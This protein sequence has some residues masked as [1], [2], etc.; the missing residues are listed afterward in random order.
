M[1]RK[2]WQIADQFVAGGV[3]RGESE[4]GLV[5]DRGHSLRKQAAAVG[6]RWRDSCLLARCRRVRRAK[7]RV[8]RVG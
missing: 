6:A 7:L 1:K 5:P 4:V 2:A 8:V 3:L